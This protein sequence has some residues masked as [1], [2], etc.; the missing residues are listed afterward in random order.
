MTKTPAPFRSYRVRH[1][2]GTPG[3]VLRVE[4]KYLSISFRENG[5][6]ETIEIAE[7]AAR[8]VWIRDFR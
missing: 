1:L 2:D 5:K 6:D 8:G 4:G 7:D 3:R